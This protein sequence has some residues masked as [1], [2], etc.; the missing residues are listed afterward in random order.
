MQAS[1][2][3][4][5]QAEWHQPIFSENGDSVSAMRGMQGALFTFL[6]VF[7]SLSAIKLTTP[8]ARSA[9]N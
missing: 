6:Q 2:A 5:N 7:K 8:L 4:R 9:R 1:W 3:G